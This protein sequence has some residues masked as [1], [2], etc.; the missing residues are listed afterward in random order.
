MYQAKKMNLS[1]DFLRSDHLTGHVHSVFG[2][3]INLEFLMDSAIGK[4]RRMITLLLSDSVMIPD[5]VIVPAPFF[6]CIKTLAECDIISV[7]KHCERRMAIT[8]EIYYVKKEKCLLYFSGINNILNL[9]DTKNICLGLEQV[10]LYAKT[11][12]M[13]Q[14]LAHVNHFRCLCNKEDGFN[15]IPSVCIKNLGTFADALLTGSYEEAAISYCSLIGTGIGLTP[16]CDDAMVGILACIC[17][18]YAAIDPLNGILTYKELTGS[19]IP[20]TQDQTTD[21]SSKYLKC[22]LRGSFSEMLYRLVCWVYGESRE[23][24]NEILKQFTD[25]GHTSGLDTLRGFET[26]V[27]RIILKKGVKGCIV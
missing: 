19:L 2:Q 6:W 18:L 4:E 23:D 9:A 22:A 11:S 27:Q 25:I 10:R 3:V 15:K 24:L 5:S 21:I 7:D 8:N 26:A 12:R 17:G 13:L 1:C 20:H 14:F 16:S